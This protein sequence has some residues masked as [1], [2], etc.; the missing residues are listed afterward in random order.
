VPVI[1]GQEDREETYASE[2]EDAIKRMME[3]AGIA[4]AKGKKP[5]FLDVDKDGDKAE[6]FAKAS[7]DK[8][9]VDESIFAM[10][11]NLWKSYKG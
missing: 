2:E 9:E 4:E 5:D 3:M 8:E 11:R 10:T 7:K 6:P 1:A